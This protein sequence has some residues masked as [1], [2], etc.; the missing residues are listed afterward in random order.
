MECDG[1]GRMKVNKWDER[2][3]TSK[4]YVLYEIGVSKEKYNIF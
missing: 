2:I 4:L 1:F 3:K